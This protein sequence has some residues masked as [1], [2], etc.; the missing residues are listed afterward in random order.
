MHE[1][2]FWVGRSIFVLCIEIFYGSFFSLYVVCVVESKVAYSIESLI[3]LVALAEQ[4]GWAKRSF[5]CLFFTHAFL[6]VVTG[7]SGVCDSVS[8]R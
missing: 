5:S 7:T 6:Y 1:V 4:P 2:S 8:N 3:M